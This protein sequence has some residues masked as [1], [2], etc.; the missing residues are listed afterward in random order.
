MLILALVRIRY[1]K[2]T[3]SVLKLVILDQSRQYGYQTVPF[4]VYIHNL[5]FVLH[6]V[7]VLKMVEVQ[8]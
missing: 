5:M 6:L 8:C 4:D 3:I 2:L 1:L 7:C